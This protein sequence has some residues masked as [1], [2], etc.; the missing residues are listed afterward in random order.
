M[1]ARCTYFPLFSA[2]T[3][4]GISYYGFNAL[5][6][7]GMAAGSGALLVVLFSALLIGFFRAAVSFP[8]DLFAQPHLRR[9]CSRAEIHVTAFSLGLALGLGAGGAVPRGISLGLPTETVTG[10]SGTLL[11]DPR[12]LA[13]GRGMAQLALRTAAD[14]RGVR[15]SAAGRLTVFF[16]DEAIPRLKD[17]GRGSLVYIDGRLA[18]GEHLLFRA[19]SAHILKAAPA[20]EQFRTGVRLGLIERFSGGAGRAGRSWGGLALA[21]LLGVRDN[22]DTDLAGFYQKAGCSHVLA[23]SG[24][25]LAI[26]SS[27]IAFFLKR[28]LGL[29]AAA[30]TGAVF[31]FFYVFLV[32]SQPSL[33]RA[34]L[35][36]LLGTLAVLGALP[37]NPGA[38]LGLAFLI[39]IVIW[40]GSGLSVSF[41]LSYLALGGIL[42]IGEALRRIFRGRIPGFLLQPLA[43]SLGAF[44]ATSAATAF[45]FGGLRPVGIAAGLFI[46]PLTTLFMIGSLA[47]LAVGL[48]SP[49]LASF[50]GDGLSLV[51][52]LMDR[53]VFGA[54]RFPGVLVSR[55]FWVLAL[56]LG[57]SVFIIWF[58]KRYGDL[59]RRLPSLA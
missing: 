59:K 35:M 10:V 31:I 52:A 18:S 33:D 56:S 32:G 26:V 7:A 14:G 19:S 11:N 40:P 47:W 54:A 23:L 28:P 58:G 44:L 27:L 46:V 34:A 2:V 29:K 16:P 3:G 13:D 21:L 39:Q 30:L 41:I 42:T 57:L 17:F 53:L 38:L 45:F 22:L 6:S 43:A 9:L 12:A 20:L 49:V 4:A 8:V 15:S 51:Y 1:V 50:T 48:F 55:P 36:Y 37:R 24:M 5:W 25:H